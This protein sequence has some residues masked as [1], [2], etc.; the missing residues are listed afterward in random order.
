MTDSTYLDWPF[1]EDRHRELK[2]ELDAWCEGY[3][4]S[5]GDDVDAVCRQLVADLG[6]A[7][8]LQNCVPELDVRSLALCRET[9]GY[10][11]GL[12]DF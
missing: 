3:D 6:K 4:F 5:H 11:S 2:R 7:G 12:A 1:L 10:H 8:I 9:L